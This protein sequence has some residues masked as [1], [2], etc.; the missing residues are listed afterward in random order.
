MIL[1]FTGTR[2]G[3]SDRQKVGLIKTMLS[4]HEH[5]GIEEVHHGCCVG[6]DREFHDFAKWLLGIHR[7]I[8]HP[9]TDKR[10]M[11]DMLL[12]LPVKQVRSPLPYL[13]RNHMIVKES[14]FLI[15]AP[16]QPKEIQRS[17]TWASVRYA[18]RIGGRVRILMP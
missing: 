13:D 18:K 3:L 2:D 16:A 14:D 9:P 17:G 8:A 5:E 6:A 11:A 10:L 1:G 7:I 4:F 15:A 12:E